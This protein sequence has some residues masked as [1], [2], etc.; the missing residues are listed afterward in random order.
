MRHDRGMAPTF[1][2]GAM[3]PYSWFSAER[4]AE[5]LP[6]AR[7]Q[8]LFLGGMFKANGRKS[9]GLDE[10]R[11]AGM[12]DCESRAAS[13]GLGPIRW[14]EQW[15]TSDLTVARAMVFA[16]QRDE[17]AP[18]ALAAMRLAFREGADL[19]ELGSVLEA[20]RRCGLDSAELELALSDPALKDALRAC[21]D[22]AV[23]RG[24]FGVPTVAVGEQLFW[25]DDRL[26][27]AAAAAAESGA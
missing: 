22:E 21:T 17:L 8:P 26:G 15:P 12:A 23:A 9:W 2:F 4:I 18:F 11:A 14:P 16:Q 25:G 13:Y 24:V 27:E 6:E 7:W 20:A 3:S 5:L 10:H 1:Y 19:A